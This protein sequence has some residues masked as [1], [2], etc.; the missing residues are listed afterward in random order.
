[1]SFDPI[2]TSADPVLGLAAVP[3]ALQAVARRPALPAELQRFMRL[4]DEF[5]Q[6][7]SQGKYL[8]AASQEW[9]ELPSNWRMALVL[10]AG[11]GTETDLS[12]LASRA[13]LEIPPP[14]R[15]EI[16]SV[17]RFGKRYFVRVTA[18]AARV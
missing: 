6:I 9:C 16:K 10:L 3:A 17:V 11:I 13:W 14:E 12:T 18:L 7:A 1:M 4:R 5:V 2:A 15:D 8:D